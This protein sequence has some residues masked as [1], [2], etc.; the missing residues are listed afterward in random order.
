[1]GLV[2]KS[3]QMLDIYIYTVYK[4]IYMDRYGSVYFVMRRWSGHWRSIIFWDILGPDWLE[5]VAAKAVD[6]GHL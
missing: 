1:M 6:A 2:A 5:L 4:Y 3:G